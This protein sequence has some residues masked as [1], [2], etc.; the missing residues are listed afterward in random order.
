MINK[1]DKMNDDEYD[2]YDE[3]KNGYKASEYEFGQAFEKA[4]ENGNLELIKY[5][6]ELGD[7]EYEFNSAVESGNLEII[8][9]LHELGYRDSE[10]EF[11]F[12]VESGNLEIMQKASEYAIDKAFEK[13]VENGNLELIKYLHELG[14]K[15]S[16]YEFGQ[17]FEKAVENGGGSLK[18]I[19]N[20]FDPEK[21]RCEDQSSHGT[22][23]EL[24]IP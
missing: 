18:V 15:A 23:L 3:D 14:Y 5:L 7:S 10:Y 16:E 20:I 8:K 17:A 22:Y 2:E 11:N 19:C 24:P 1:D 21:E 13:A 6:H 12:A 9:Y 4:V